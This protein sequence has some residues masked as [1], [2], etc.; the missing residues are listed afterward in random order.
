[1]IPPLLFL[2]ALAVGTAAAVAIAHVLRT[3][4]SARVAELAARWE[5]RFTADD[6]FQL[7]P[8]VAAQLPHPGAADV[9]V[10]DLIYGQQ[11]SGALRYYFTVEYTVGVVRTKR[12]R[13]AVGTLLESAIDTE[14][15]PFSG[16][17]LAPND[18]PLPDQYQWLRDRQPDA[19]TPPQPAGQTPAPTAVTPP[20]Q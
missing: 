8:R 3:A 7:T 9:L 17:T 13:V 20:E 6:R 14:R 5:L 1:L 16:V 11:P 18:L 10:R 4:R 19:A 2:A 12:R 15:E